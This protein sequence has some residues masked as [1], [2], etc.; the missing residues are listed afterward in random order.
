MQEQI[1]PVPF[2]GDTLVMVDHN[3]QPFVAMKSVVENMGLAWQSQ[4]AKLK[5]KFG[6]VIT[7]IVT[8]AGDGKNYEMTCLPLRKLAAWLY[9][10][11]P[12]KVAEHLR[13][14]VR[15][16][17]DECDDALWDYW[18]KGAAVRG[19]ESAN[20]GHQLSAINTHLKLLDR[21]E[22]ER[23]PEKRSVI[24]QQLEYV[25]RMLGFETPD[26][27]KL[28]FA[29]ETSGH[30]PLLGEFWDMVEYI[31]VDKLN[32]SHDPELIAINLPHLA[33]MAIKLK[34]PLVNIAACRRALSRSAAPKFIESN[35]VVNSA[36]E[37][38]AMRCWIFSA[39]ANGY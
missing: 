16:Y 35:R 2:H 8:T 17:Q 22:A 25:S 34:V 28:G 10:I 13:D 33:K 38:R 9:S 7:I 14:K 29:Q 36:L 11:N 37:K 21:L 5:E 39:L 6:S 12:N 19:G 4:H 30:D 18:T 15:Q 24:Y 32:H 23:H 26:I 27:N 31:G 20:T 3:N 1:L